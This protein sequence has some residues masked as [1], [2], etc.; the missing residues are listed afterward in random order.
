[1]EEFSHEISKTYQKLHRGGVALISLA[2]SVEAAQAI[3]FN[4]SWTGA[5]GY[6]LTGMFG[7]ND[8]LIG[9]GPI[10]GSQL[11][12]FMMEVFQN[13]TSLGTWQPSQGGSFN[14]NFNTTTAQFLVG[15]NSATST[16]QE[17]GFSGSPS[18]I[19]GSGDL[20]QGVGNPGLINASFIPVSQ[21]TL[22][23]TV[24]QPISV[25]EPSSPLAILG[26][27]TAVGFG[28]FLKRKLA[29]SKKK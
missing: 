28:A 16:G 13:T 8:S 9:T 14:F 7:Y 26:A 17:W 20:L 2:F 21:S 25:P 12:F 18:V 15:G 19:F 1:V 3:S 27:G 23:A 4:I 5:N 29:Q 24:K 11:D 6:N 22:T 10:T